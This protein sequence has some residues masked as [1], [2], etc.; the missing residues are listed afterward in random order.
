MKEQ[1]KVTTKALSKEMLKKSILRKKEKLRERVAVFLPSL[2]EAKRSVVPEGIKLRWP[3]MAGL[4]SV[5][6]VY[7]SQSD[8]IIEA[9]TRN[10]MLWKQEVEKLLE[11]K[12]EAKKLE[13]KEE[14]KGKKKGKKVW[15]KVGKKVGKKEETEEETKGE[16]KSETKDETKQQTMKELVVAGLES[17]TIRSPRRL[18]HVCR[19]A[20]LLRER[21]QRVDETM[22]QIE[23]SLDEAMAHFEGKAK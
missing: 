23:R 4:T 7:A 8:M 5:P 11:K 21:L 20:V 14:M 3:K 9:V 13:K 18:C 12:L 16:T 10:Y 19:Q 6:M 15:K 17:M 2:G 22:A 1:P